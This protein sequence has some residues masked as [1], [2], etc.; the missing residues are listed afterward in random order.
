MSNPYPDS[1][2]ILLVEDNPG[3]KRLVREAFR[4]S[5]LELTFSTVSDGSEALEYLTERQQTD[6]A[7]PDLL[8][9]DLNLPQT[10][11]FD[12]MET[13]NEDPELSKVPILV[14][15][16]SEDKDDI[17]SS[18]GLSA[19]AYLSKPDSPTEFA[20]LAESVEAFWFESAHLPPEPC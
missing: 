2:D 6:P 16:S 3:D 5:T 18:Y 19:N 12:V 11:G 9:L 8:L 4:D 17:R 1:V 20:T 14:L 10:S 7:F 13:M 15:T